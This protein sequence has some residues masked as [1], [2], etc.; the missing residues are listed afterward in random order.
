VRFRT[1][2]PRRL[3]AALA[4]SVRPLPPLV[5]PSAPLSCSPRCLR[6][7]VAAPRAAFGAAFVRPSPPLSCGPRRL[8]HAA[9]AASFV[10]PSPPSCGTRPLNAALAAFMRP[11]PPSCGPRRLH[12]VLAAFMRPSPPSCGPPS[13]PPHT[14]LGLVV[15]QGPLLAAALPGCRPLLQSSLHLQEDAVW[16]GLLWRIV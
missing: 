11:S 3:C 5:R 14:G 15:L 2:G 9:L 13:S 12:A 1:A 6:A 7:T 10:R 4:A 16:G 8:F